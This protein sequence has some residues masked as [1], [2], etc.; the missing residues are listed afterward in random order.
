M[1]ST[2]TEKRK[3]TYDWPM[4]ALT[5]DGVVFGFDPNDQINPLKILLICRAEMP[6]IGHWAIPG[7]HVNI[8]ED[9]G[10][11]D[12]VRREVQEETGARFEYLEQLYTFGNPGRDPRGRVVSVAYLALVRKADYES[13]VG[14]DDADLAVWTPVNKL[15][16]VKL[17][18]D[19]RRIL[20][21][22]LKRLQGKIRYAPIGFDLLP[23]K[24]TLGQ[25]QQLY[26]AILQRN[27]GKSN[28]R[29]RILDMGILIETGST[30]KLKSG[31]PARLYRFDTKAYEKAVERGFNFEL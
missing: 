16:Q 18:F 6:F 17:A 13:V 15:G 24:F 5:V 12:A 25:L 11:E 26:E 3:Y 22:A 28:F 27:L 14:G 19:H 31:R 2:R 9:E 20:S 1:S 8:G 29:R 30:A 4:A 7:G 21:I 10:L 23:S